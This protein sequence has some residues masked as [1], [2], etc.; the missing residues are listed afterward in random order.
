MN[1]LMIDPSLFAFQHSKEILLALSTTFSTQY[2]SSRLYLPQVLT[3]KPAEFNEHFF[4]RF[5]LPCNAT[6]RRTHFHENI[7]ILPTLAASYWQT[8]PAFQSP[9]ISI[10]DP[11]LKELVV[12]ELSFLTRH[13]AVL[14][15]TKKV[16]QILQHAGVPTKDVS[17]SRLS[18]KT[19]LLGTHPRAKYYLLTGTPQES[20][21]SK[22]NIVISIFDP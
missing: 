1:G 14:T 10:S 2:P 8:P 5:F 7:T 16:F 3:K 12:E 20:H 6:E 13:S 11:L 9:P 18:I 22:T 19:R 21:R 4:N 15:K 17:E